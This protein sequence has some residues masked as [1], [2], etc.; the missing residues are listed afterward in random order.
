MLNVSD[1]MILWMSRP[2]VL[3]HKHILLVMFQ[4]FKIIQDF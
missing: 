4:V 3:T 1:M 2:G